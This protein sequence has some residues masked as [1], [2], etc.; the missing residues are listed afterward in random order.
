V[1][2]VTRPP[3]EPAEVSAERAR[4]AGREALLL[5]LCDRLDGAQRAG[6]REAASRA[7]FL[8]VTRKV[9]LPLAAAHFPG[10]AA[11]LREAL[12]EAQA[13]S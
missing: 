4:T 7:N 5:R 10:L 9:Y 8:A 2:A 6:G 11:A 12:A 1:A 13:A 3:G